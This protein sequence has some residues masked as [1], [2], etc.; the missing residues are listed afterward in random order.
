M[1]DIKIL[2]EDIETVKERL[3]VKNYDLDVELFLSLERQR[4]ES[5][6]QVEE[7]QQQINILSKKFGELK[8]NKLPTVEISDEIEKVKTN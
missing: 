7:H 6:I 1:I 8:K 4:K 5:Q 2:R 3:S